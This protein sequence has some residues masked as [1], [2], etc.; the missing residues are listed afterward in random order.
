M[1]G[2]TKTVSVSDTGFAAGTFPLTVTQAPPCT[3]VNL[4]PSSFSVSSGFN[5]K[6]LADT[7]QP[8]IVVTT[9]GGCG[10]DM[11]VRFTQ[12][13][14]FVPT[15]LT[16]TPVATTPLA[17][18]TSWTVDMVGRPWQKNKNV[19]FTVLNNQTS[20]GSKAVSS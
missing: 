13:G 15:T 11:A 20:I 9:A 17:L 4:T 12:P 8:P 3:F 5:G 7:N 19:T 18:P 6:I 14:Q 1:P 2:I 10:P 16:L